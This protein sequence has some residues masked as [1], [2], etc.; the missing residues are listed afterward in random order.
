M[1]RVRRARQQKRESGFIITWDVD[2]ADRS[3]SN[4]LHRFMYGDETQVDGRLYRYPGFVDWDGV[5][6]LGQSV[7]FVRPE[8][9]RE[10]DAFLAGAGIDHESTRAVLG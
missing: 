10:V 3:G 4:R 6:Y 9:L 1:R 8:F 7:V 5:R 2:S